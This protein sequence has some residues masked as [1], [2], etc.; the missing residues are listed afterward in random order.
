MNQLNNMV[1]EGILTDDPRLISAKEGG[2]RFVK[3]SIANHR[4][5]KDSSGTFQ[6]EV[7]FMPV[8]TWGTLALQ[9]E[10]NLRKGMVCRICGRL[11]MCKWKT[12]EGEDRKTMELVASYVEF[13]SKMN[14]DQQIKLC[15]P[16]EEERSVSE[17]PVYYEF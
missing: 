17:P 10:K 14:P 4:G 7:L 6:D 9:C 13:Y 2:V 12:K 11:R 3:F 15:V 1:I 5:W 8:Q 16:E